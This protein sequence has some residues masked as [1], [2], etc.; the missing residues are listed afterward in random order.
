MGRG[1]GGIAIRLGARGLGVAEVVLFVGLAAS[2]PLAKL[3]LRISLEV[4]EGDAK[5]TE[6]KSG[7]EGGEIRRF[8]SV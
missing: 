6:C 4:A 3:A 1:G 7:L 8:I 5:E 2:V